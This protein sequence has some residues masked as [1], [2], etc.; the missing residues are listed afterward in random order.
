ADANTREP[1]LAI[2]CT[3]CKGRLE[4]R[5]PV[6]CAGCLAP[7]HGDCWEEHGRCAPCGVP[8]HVRPEHTAARPRRR[9]GPRF[10]TLAAASIAGLV[11]AAALSSDAVGRFV[12][13]QF[14]ALLVDTET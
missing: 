7:H 8:R 10:A 13:Q 5:E 14:L 11:G 9:R 12:R 2:T 6:Y 1:A 4:R 3:Y